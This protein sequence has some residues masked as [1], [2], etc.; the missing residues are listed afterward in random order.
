MKSITYKEPSLEDVFLHY[1]GRAYRE[2]EG[3]EKERMK[4]RMRV[5]GRRR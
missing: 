1:T 3:S 2:E 5:M 4:M